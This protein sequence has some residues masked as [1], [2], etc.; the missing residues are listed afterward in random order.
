MGGSSGSPFIALHAIERV[1]S[2]GAARLYWKAAGKA[3][4]FHK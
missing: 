4:L 2:G 1:G 3:E